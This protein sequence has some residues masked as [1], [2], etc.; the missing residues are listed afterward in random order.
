MENRGE[1]FLRIL[2]TIVWSVYAKG[3]LY[4]KFPLKKHATLGPLYKVHLSQSKSILQGPS[5]F[6]TLNLIR[7]AKRP[8][9]AHLDARN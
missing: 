9:L 1:Y 2:D 4:K 3:Q 8:I 5:T 6:N 7:C